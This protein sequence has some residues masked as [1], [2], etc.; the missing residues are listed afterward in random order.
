MLNS[1]QLIE[2]TG[3]SRATLNNYVALGI[4]PAPVIK[5]P[6]ENE[7][8]A[9][10]LGYFDKSAAER[11]RQVQ[12]L[13]RQGMSMAQIARELSAPIEKDDEVAGTAPE[14]SRSNQTA[15]IDNA[16]SS[17][18]SDAG[19]GSPGKLPSFGVGQTLSFDG[20]IEDLPGPAYLVN[21][22]FE[23][24]WWNSKAQH[25]FFNHNHDLPSD[26]ES[27]NILKLL[28]S[29]E[30]ATDADRMRDL[31]RPHLAAGKKRLSHQALIK[32]YSALD[33]DQLGI[34]KDLYEQVEP[35]GKAP[36]IHF[37]T[38]LIDSDG[39]LTPHDLYICF[40]REGIFFTYSPVV[41]EDDYLLDFLRKRNQVINELLKNRKPYLTHVAVMMADVQNSVKICSELPA[42]EYFELI[43]TIWQESA[44]I[45]RKYYGTYGKHAGDGMVYYFFP[46]PDC[47]YK[48]NAIQC[49][50]EL[51]TLM[52]KITRQWQ[53]RKGWFSDIYLNIG[54]N[55]GEEW[56]GSYHAGGHVEF[57]VLGETINYASRISDFARD[58]SVWAT[59][60]MLSQIP[61]DDRKKL[62]FGI[63]RTTDSNE[64]V[65]VTDTYACVGSL[66]DE[67]NSA[68]DKFKDIEMIPVSEVRAMNEPT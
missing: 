6:G 58:G 42:E 4:L 19:Q 27:R 33:G 55:E 45:F 50:L 28:F 48:L 22:N 15:I 17:L 10:R 60:S 53:A 7:G 56:F 13:K 9:T 43:N 57:T 51:Q 38:M 68:S 47:D 34:L 35:V 20:T 39:K 24:I 36:M 30:S 5:T 65:F 62:S 14:D 49:S 40:Y 3:I 8:R 41:L 25:D 63:T 2:I 67:G 61:R 66:I 59:K 44:P 46:Q 32:V 18:S 31:L 12:L 29:T 16:D 23:L 11:I 21:N 26:L 64:S 1:K 37:P 52:K 54:L